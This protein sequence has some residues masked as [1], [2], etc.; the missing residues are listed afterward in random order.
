MRADKSIHATYVGHRNYYARCTAWRSTSQGDSP[1]NDI[2]K[3]PVAK[4]LSRKGLPPHR[5]RIHHRSDEATNEEKHE[6]S[7]TRR[8]RFGKVVQRNKTANSKKTQK[9]ELA[10]IDLF[11]LN[12]LPDYYRPD[13]SNLL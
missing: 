2:A 11:V 7:L 5:H 12:D 6:K 8:L 10:D 4:G 13:A 9:Q 3:L 1:F